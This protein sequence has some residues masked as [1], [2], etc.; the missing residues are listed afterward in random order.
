[1]KERL[2]IAAVYGLLVVA[3]GA[4]VVIGLAQPIHAQETAPTDV[5]SP[6]K[7]PNC[8]TVEEVAKLLTDK[9]ETVVILDAKS[10][11]NVTTEPGSGRVVMATFGSGDK[12]VVFGFEQEGCVNGP[13][14]IAKIVPDKGA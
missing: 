5:Q 8:P 10:V 4:L 3:A 7:D 12:Y 2:A 11:L 9:G 14:A 1:M 13:N 6:F